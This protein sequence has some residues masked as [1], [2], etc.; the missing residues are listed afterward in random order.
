MPFVGTRL[1]IMFPSCSGLCSDMKVNH[2]H[3]LEVLGKI[4]LLPLSFKEEAGIWWCVF[5]GIVCC[6][7]SAGCDFRILH[8]HRTYYYYLDT[9]MHY[10][11]FEG[12]F[13]AGVVSKIGHDIV[14]LYRDGTQIHCRCGKLFSDLITHI[15]NAFLSTWCVMKLTELAGNM[16]GLRVLTQKRAIWSMRSRNQMINKQ[17]SLGRKN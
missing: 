14:I 1:C 8:A 16:C 10:T 4:Y 17:G 7:I 13:M 9:K 15:T 2:T 5:V 6:R 12:L 3:R 11:K